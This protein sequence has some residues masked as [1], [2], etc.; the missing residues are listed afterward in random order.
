MC[1]LMHTYVSVARCVRTCRL[2]HIYVQADATV[3][4]AR[5][6][7]THFKIGSSHC[8]LQKDLDVF[9]KLQSLFRTQQGLFLKS[10]V[11]FS[12]KGR[13]Y[14]FTKSIIF[15][16]PFILTSLPKHADNQLVNND[17]VPFIL[18]S[19]TLSKSLQSCPQRFQT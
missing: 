4:A 1:K 11:C 3:C 14:P 7:R 2:T 13:L 17:R 6:V 8:I 5:C 19:V 9:K 18:V 12:C 15:S 10:S 16:F